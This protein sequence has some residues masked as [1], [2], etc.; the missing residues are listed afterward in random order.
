MNVNNMLNSQVERYKENLIEFI[1]V[2]GLV[3]DGKY[4]FDLTEED[5]LIYR[6]NLGHWL[7]VPQSFGGFRDIL[8]N[9][10]EELIKAID[11]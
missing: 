2:M 1:G 10:S 7:P 5:G 9:L 11:Y 4:Q 8:A 3:E 6:T